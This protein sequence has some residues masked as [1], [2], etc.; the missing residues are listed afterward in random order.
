MAL[1]CHVR[2][3]IH[4]GRKFMIAIDKIS[5]KKSEKLM[6]EIYCI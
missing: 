4:F 5:W 2:D 1:E 3:L 6:Q